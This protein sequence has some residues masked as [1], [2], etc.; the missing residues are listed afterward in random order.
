MHARSRVPLVAPGFYP[1]T[2]VPLSREISSKFRN[3]ELKFLISLQNKIRKY[4]VHDKVYIREMKSIRSDIFR[5]LFLNNSWIMLDGGEEK[6]MW[7]SDV[8]N[9]CV[10]RK[11][12][13]SD[14]R[15]EAGFRKIPGNRGVLHFETGS[16][17]ISPVP[18]LI[19]NVWSRL[20][21][22]TMQFICGEFDVS[23]YEAAV[24]G[25]GNGSNRFATRIGVSKTRKPFFHRRKKKKGKRGI[26]K[27][28][29]RRWNKTTS[30]RRRERE[31]NLTIFNHPLQPRLTDIY[32]LRRDT[33]RDQY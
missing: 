29:I 20:S 9:S 16:I 11:L 27:L 6:K 10:R 19:V 1:R 5:I 33:P 24:R 23:A 13:A 26:I 17:N 31:W 2:C 8:R 28:M 18:D 7:R 12:S 21:W 22:N 4:W 3:P 14:L 15:G 30:S 25:G 32:S